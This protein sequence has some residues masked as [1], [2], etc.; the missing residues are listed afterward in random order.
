MSCAGAAVRHPEI[1]YPLSDRY[2]TRRGSSTP[3]LSGRRNWRRGTRAGLMPS[4][5]VTPV[6]QPPFDFRP[7]RE[8]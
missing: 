2:Q 5:W 3:L 7:N 1:E 8:F 6:G 4:L